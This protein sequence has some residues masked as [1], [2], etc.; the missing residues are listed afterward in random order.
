MEAIG[1]RFISLTRRYLQCGCVQPS[2]SQLDFFISNG[3]K[4]S[5]FR[6]FSPLCVQ[7]L[8]FSAVKKL[9]LYE[10]LVHIG[11]AS[12][13]PELEGASSILPIWRPEST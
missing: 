6:T 12:I 5:L 8:H 2:N 10:M 4:R 7:I 1:P 3:G 13:K 9:Q 11:W